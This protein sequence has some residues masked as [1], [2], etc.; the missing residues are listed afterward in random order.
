M[1]DGGAFLCI[2][3]NMVWPLGL[4]VVLM[5][6]LKTCCKNEDNIE[7]Y[8]DYE[9]DAHGDDDGGAHDEEVGRL[10]LLNELSRNL[11]FAPLCQ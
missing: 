6:S 8:N 7:G 2:W 11:L 9:S 1:G 5:S 4:I 10:S 3:S